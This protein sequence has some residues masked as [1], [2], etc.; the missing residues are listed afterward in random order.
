MNEDSHQSHVNPTGRPAKLIK[1]ILVFGIASGSALLA[2]FVAVVGFNETAVNVLLLFGVVSFF[3]M[4]PVLEFVNSLA[5]GKMKKQEERDLRDMEERK[6][7]QEAYQEDLK[8]AKKEE[9]MRQIAVFRDFGYECREIA[10]VLA[11][12]HKSGPNGEVPQTLPSALAKFLLRKGSPE[13]V[14][15]ER[16]LPLIAREEATHNEI[17]SFGISAELIPML[18]GVTS[19]EFHDEVHEAL[20]NQLQVLSSG[21]GDLNSRP[22]DFIRFEVLLI[23]G[24]PTDIVITTRKSRMRGEQAVFF[25]IVPVLDDWVELDLTARPFNLWEQISTGAWRRNSSRYF[26]GGENSSITFGPQFEMGEKRERFSSAIV[27]LWTDQ[28]NRG[29]TMRLDALANDEAL[30]RKLKIRVVQEKNPYAV[31]DVFQWDQ[32]GYVQVVG[33]F[34][35]GVWEAWEGEEADRPL[36]T[37]LL[38]VSAPNLLVLPYSSSFRIESSEQNKLLAGFLNSVSHHRKSAV[39]SQGGNFE[40]RRGPVTHGSKIHKYFI[41]LA[42]NASVTKFIKPAPGTGEG[43]KDFEAYQN[44]P[45]S[46]HGFSPLEDQGFSSI[47]ASDCYLRTGSDAIQLVL[48]VNLGSPAPG[49]SDRGVSYANA[50]LKAALTNFARRAAISDLEILE[51][52]SAQGLVSRG[53]RE[54]EEMGKSSV[55]YVKLLDPTHGSYFASVTSARKLIQS[56]ILPSEIEIHQVDTYG[57]SKAGMIPIFLMPEYR[58]VEQ[59]LAEIEPGTSEGALLLS[60]IAAELSLFARRTLE[61][62]IVCS[63]FTLSDTF[64]DSGEEDIGGYLTGLSP[65]AG[66]PAKPRFFVGDFGSYIEKIAFRREATI[67]REQYRPPEDLD[68]SLR[69]HAEPYLVYLLGLL[70]IEVYSGEPGLT[71]EPVI[72]LRLGLSREEY[73]QRI[74]SQVPALLPFAPDGVVEKIVTMLAYDP[75]DRPAL[76]DL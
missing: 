29:R 63:D 43:F 15:I 9:L 4:I 47:P 31:A 13:Q 62:G 7:A 40:L 34:I 18:K 74:A 55:W 70:W 57:Q 61:K 52:K 30:Q 20:R 1:P 64:V 53:R 75:D 25:Q 23:P 21:G 17:I 68:H 11:S 54:G 73:S 6:L 45:E 71:I 49:E 42:E 48:Q 38:N 33:W 65:S 37:S 16:L 59:C 22:Q 67:T 5:K 19:D 72:Q 50:E 8:R 56:G 10:E 60:R 26:Y 46:R 14:A 36:L 66:A 44:L 58:S 41:K 32:K 76:A 51:E 12:V 35:D 27:D 2:I 28:L 69:F 3:L 39:F 24:I